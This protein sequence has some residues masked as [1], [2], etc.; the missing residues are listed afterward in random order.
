MSL[1]QRRNDTLDAPLP[2]PPP[3][4]LSGP[5][6]SPGVPR[7]LARQLRLER[8]QA[9][10]PEELAARLEESG[11]TDDWLREHD[12]GDVFEVAARLYA[13]KTG[14]PRPV[15]AAPIKLP[16]RRLWRG[17]ML[18]LIGLAALSSAR[19]LGVPEAEAAVCAAAAV[20]WGLLTWGPLTWGPGAGQ[21]WPRLRLGAVLGALAGALTALGLAASL[22]AASTPHSETVELWRSAGL[23]ALLGGLYGLTLTAAGLLLALG[24]WR[25]AAL[26]F[27]S[28]L[29]IGEGLRRSAPDGW[30]AALAVAVLLGLVV[31]AVGAAGRPGAEPSPTDPDGD[32]SGAVWTGASRPGDGWAS[33]LALAVLTWRVGAAALL[34]ALLSLGLLEALAWWMQAHLRRLAGQPHAPARLLRAARWPVLGVP[35][36]LL[37]AVAAGSAAAQLGWTSLG[38][39]G[40]GWTGFEWFG[41][42]GAAPGALGR[43]CGGALLSVALLQS[44]WLARH[45]RQRPRLTRLWLLCAGLL[46]AP[47]A[48]WW[49]PLLLL[50]LTLTLLSDD[51]LSDL[52]TYR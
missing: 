20:A 8:R 17:P 42:G 21:R 38:W 31:T 4:P 10:D 35:A 3:A 9:A 14:G 52:T 40:S 22:G 33:G 16:W 1:G 32:R 27:G 44:T 41:L 50:V 45:P 36:A 34:W 12:L 49:L 11:H 23:G 5:P 18:V 2:G 48:S 39:P 24:R 43:A 7:Q 13:L 28:A 15:V 29:L 19:G 30:S 26:V 37:V 51:A 46:A 6:T 47:L 25:V